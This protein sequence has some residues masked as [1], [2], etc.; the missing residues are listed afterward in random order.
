MTPHAN[1][2]GRNY[3]PISQRGRLRL[4]EATSLARSE[5]RAC[6]SDPDI[7]SCPEC[8]HVKPQQQVHV[9][10]L[11]LWTQ[12]R[13]L[14][15]SPHQ[16]QPRLVSESPPALNRHRPLIPSRRE[17][18]PAL[19]QG[20]TFPEGTTEAGGSTNEKWV[21]FPQWGD[22]GLSACMSV[23]LPAG[24]T[25][26]STPRMPQQGSP[27]VRTGGPA[28]PLARPSRHCLGSTEP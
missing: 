20:K 3:H 25:R 21:V 4:P 10:G 24:V 6:S 7:A 17:L 22:A 14:V 9:A 8:V 26:P 16:G 27:G 2:T 12:P 11:E 23:C 28:S 18:A 1:T 13:T 19:S 15:S 5:P